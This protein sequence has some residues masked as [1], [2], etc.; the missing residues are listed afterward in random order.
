MSYG[1]DSAVDAKTARGEAWP[2]LRQFSVFME[3]RVG[4]LQELFRLL[5]RHDLRI[6]A[7]NVVDSFEFSSVRLMV[8]QAD[9]AKELFDL[10][11]FTVLETDVVG[12][13]ISEDPQPLLQICLG[14][15]EVELNIHYMYPL[16][17]RRGGHGA[18]A[19]HVDDID[20]A[21]NTLKAKNHIII[22]ENDLMDDD[23][24]FA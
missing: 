10:S 8:D 24:Y 15:M 6:I 21:M 1:D 2:C 18:I 4:G 22:T 3:N 16:L 7:L 23:E 12:V 9:R 13:Q 20:L 19:F 17:Y 11:N 5:E 14:L